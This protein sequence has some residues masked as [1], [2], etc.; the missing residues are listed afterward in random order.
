MSL[1]KFIIKAIVY[2]LTFVASFYAINSINFEK[3]LKKNSVK[4]AQLLYMLLAMALAYL[5]GSFILSF[6][7][8]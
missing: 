1:A 6:V 4:Q 7:Y 3:L 8:L 5:V 2:G